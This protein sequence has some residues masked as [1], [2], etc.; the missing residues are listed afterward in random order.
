MGGGWT[1]SG[2]VAGGGVGD[3][4]GGCGAGVSVFGSSIS[5]SGLRTRTVV[6]Y[7]NCVSFR[8]FPGGGGDKIIHAIREE[9]H[10]LVFQ[11]LDFNEVASAP[12][13]CH[14]NE[15]M[16]IT[17]RLWKIPSSDSADSSSFICSLVPPTVVAGCTSSS[18]SASSLSSSSS[19]LSSSSDD[20]SSLA[21]GFLLVTD[22][23]GCLAAERAFRVISCGYNLH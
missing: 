22:D 11:E 1:D 3:M 4:G 17:D 2:S 23:D 12:T 16:A 9:C 7:F 10:I 6:T 14:L 15:I 5:D 20:S 8:S 19:S 13:H 18:D 21:G